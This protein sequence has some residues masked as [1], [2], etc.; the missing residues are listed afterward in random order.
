MEWILG[1]GFVFLLVAG[2][3]I[4]AGAQQ[5]DDPQQYIDDRRAGW[6]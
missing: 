4:W 3:I 1:L 5:A 2:I 6:E